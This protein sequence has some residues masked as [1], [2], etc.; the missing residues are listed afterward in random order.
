[1]KTKLI[2]GLGALLFPLLLLAQAETS[3]PKAFLIIKSPSF[4]KEI[5]TSNILLEA[6]DIAKIEF[7]PVIEAEK[8]FGKLPSMQSATVTLNPGVKISTLSQFYKIHGVNENK[9][10]LPFVINGETWSDTT[11]LL[12][13]ESSLNVINIKTDSIQIMTAGYLHQMKNRKN[14]K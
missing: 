7:I 11:N 6:S 1:M 4:S 14:I 3:K 13:V 8:R 12:I 10:K 2:I 9:R 5:L